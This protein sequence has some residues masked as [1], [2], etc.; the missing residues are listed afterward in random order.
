MYQKQLIL[1]HQK[2]VLIILLLIISKIY[3]KGYAFGQY[4]YFYFAS[5]EDI[6]TLNLPKPIFYIDR[7]N[8]I[9]L[10]I[11]LDQENKII[12]APA[13]TLNLFK[14]DSIFIKS[15]R[16]DELLKINQYPKNIYIKLTQHS[17]FHRF[18]L[19]TYFHF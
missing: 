7:Q 1:L 8:I 3:Y 9:E 14:K 15:K 5:F 18:I 12:N 17:S 2:L 13:T 11:H 19:A 16:G 6:I 10:H 4:T